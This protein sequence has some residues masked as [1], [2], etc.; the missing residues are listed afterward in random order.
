MQRHT[1]VHSK[2]LYVPGVDLDAS[3]LVQHPA[4]RQKRGGA[5]VPTHPALIEAEEAAVEAQKAAG[6]AT[7]L[8][9][10]V[11]P[12][13]KSF[14]HDLSAATIAFYPFSTIGAD[15]A[16]SSSGVV[17]FEFSYTDKAGCSIQPG[18]ASPGMP[19]DVHKE[20]GDGVGDDDGSWAVDG[21]RKQLW[22]DGRKPWE[23]NW[24]GGDVIGLAANV[25]VGKIAVSKNGNWSAPGHG[26]VFSDDKVKEGVYP[27]ITAGRCELHYR[28]A[29]PF[30]HGP[31][32]AELWA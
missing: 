14:I 11:G 4:M 12:P 29:A 9:R 19:I 22:N 2:V 3:N 30:Q 31:P 10:L 13:G 25:D 18:F 6:S 16:L 21:D 28:I 20:T 24:M 5:P 27:A 7:V 26:I 32:P 8:R 1:L 17:Y 23:G 15:A